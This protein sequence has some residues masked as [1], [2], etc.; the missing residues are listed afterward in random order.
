[1][2]IPKTAGLSH[3]ADV[4]NEQALTFHYPIK[5]RRE[6]RRLR[7][8]LDAIRYLEIEAE[9]DTEIEYVQQMDGSDRE[10]NVQFAYGRGAKS[11]PRPMF[12]IIPRDA[13]SGMGPSV[14]PCSC[15]RFDYSWDYT[16]C[17][18]HRE[19]SWDA[20][21]RQWAEGPTVDTTGRA[22]YSPAP[23]NEGPQGIL[24][25]M[26]EQIL[27]FERSA[28]Q[29]YT[30][31]DVYRRI[32]NATEDS[33]NCAGCSAARERAGRPNDTLRPIEDEARRQRIRAEFD[34]NRQRPGYHYDFASDRWIA[35]TNDGRAF[36]SVEVQAAEQARQVGGMEFSGLD[37]GALL[38]IDRTPPELGPTREQFQRYLGLQDSEITF[39]GTFELVVEGETQQGNRSTFSI[40]VE[41]PVDRT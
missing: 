6:P 29:A 32:I 40:E 18:A 2:T 24:A 4:A 8:N 14:K 11:Y 15:D 37:V 34:P 38:G 26:Y 17:E 22:Y 13:F 9:E 7:P 30:S 23:N 39:S 33:C 35:D 28:G 36:F 10:L 25:G 21:R 31:E 3:L 1:M 19:I 20:E 41:E 12:Q 5:K 16:R 27:A